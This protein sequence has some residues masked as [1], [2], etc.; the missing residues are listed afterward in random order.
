[1]PRLEGKVAVITGGSSGIGLG[2]A[3]RFAKEGA[4]VFITG[5]RQPE[6]EKAVAEIGPAA[7]AIQA[8]V[9]KL[10]D[11]DKIVDAVKKKA[12]RIDVL[13]LN[14]A[15]GELV[16]L[17]QITEQ[18]YDNTFNTNVRA[19]VFGLQKA[20]PILSNKASVI[21]VGSAA[22]DRAFPNFSIYSGTKGALRSFARAWSVELADRGI[23][24]N[25][26]V[27][28]TTSTPGLDR[29]VPVEHQKAAFLTRGLLPAR[30][31]KPEDMAAAA[32]FLAS[33]E[34]EFMNG[35]EL[36][37]DGGLMQV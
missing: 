16:G 2:T 12:G 27:P 23:R 9:S 5:R 21:L 36:L 11:L 20:L 4:R 32:L 19:A 8:D 7:T 26:L 31:G 15:F 33:D 3:K 6:L 22:A 10:E 28:G 18:H 14:A 13:M 30:L 1:M 24:V 34:S 25:V 29:L 17:G 35:S 37:C